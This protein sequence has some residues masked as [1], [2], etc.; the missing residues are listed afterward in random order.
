MYAKLIGIILLTTLIACKKSNTHFD[1]MTNKQ[2]TIFSSKEEATI[3]VRQ[4]LLDKQPGEILRTIE[5]I[6]YIH[7]P[8]RIVAMVFYQTNTGAH[9]LVI[10]KKTDQNEEM[11]GESITVCDGDS[12]ACKVTAKI[13]NL[14]N[15]DI[16]CNCSSCMLITTQ[17]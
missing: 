8:T 7:T 4:F 14:G 1:E 10:E 6:S 11:R 17:H 3:K 13:D 5:N 15:V 16:G 12:C 2:A 9:N